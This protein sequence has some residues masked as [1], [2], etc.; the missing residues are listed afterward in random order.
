[1]ARPITAFFVHMP[2]PRGWRGRRH[3]LSDI[4]VISILATICG[5]KGWS[6]MEAFAQ[7]KE[8]WLRTFL[9]LPNGIPSEDTFAAVFRALRP[10]VFED[11]FRAWIKEAAG[12]IGGVISLDGKTV[13]GSSSS[14]EHSAVHMVSA[15][16]AENRLV[17]AQVAVN[18]KSNEITAIPELLRMLALRGLIVTIDAMGCQKS[19]AA[20]IKKQGGDY[21]LTV[22]DNQPTLRRDIEEMFVWAE[23]RGYDGLRHAS[24]Q[25]TEKGHG[26]VETRT[27]DVLWNLAQIT[28][29][30]DWPGL[31]CIVRV[32]ATRTIGGNTS[33]EDRYYISS[34]KD[35]RAE[36]L[37]KAIRT[38]WGIEN[39][40]H[41]V[42]DLNFREDDSQ[43]RKGNSAQNL[44]RVRRIAVNL[45]N[46]D[47]VKKSVRKKMFIAGLDHDYLLKLVGMSPKATP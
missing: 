42:L 3:Q 8:S 43:V 20:Q 12:E 32:R 1:M 26:R 15:W 5:A 38:H 45:I 6:D 23:N 37:A 35:A 39:D 13:R 16:A 27:A 4:I 33:T 29:A 7:Q 21:V 47:P 40:L 18:E 31:S 28:A 34:V 46:L 24:S 2:D 25:E 10:E 36:T 11:H 41:W 22:K 44:S 19:I 14:G 17:L 30:A 9:E